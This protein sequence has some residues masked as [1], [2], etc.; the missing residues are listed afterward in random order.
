MYLG[1]FILSMVFVLVA[2]IMK[3]R[4]SEKSKIFPTKRIG[5]FVGESGNCS[6][7]FIFDHKG[8]LPENKIGKVAVGYDCGSYRF[9]K[10]Y[11]C[12]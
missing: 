10:K 3:K 8:L 6:P 11:E 4:R 5:K 9:V 2:N 1:L 12:L 7:E